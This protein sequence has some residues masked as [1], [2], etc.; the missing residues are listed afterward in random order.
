VYLYLDAKC[1]FLNGKINEEIYMRLPDQF[2]DKNGKACHLKRSIYCLRQAPRAWNEE[3]TRD[4]KR[5]GYKE[6][7]H[8]E[9][10]FWKLYEGE[11]VYLLIYVDDILVMVS[12]ARHVKE[13]KD[14]ISR[15][16]TIK[17]FGKAECFLGIKLEQTVL[18]RVD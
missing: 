13:V 8:E 18:Y 4:Q 9:S 10:M 14:E 6:F 7:Q 17:D 15:L 3:L 5:I 2:D 11:Q 12:S 16:Y 1:A